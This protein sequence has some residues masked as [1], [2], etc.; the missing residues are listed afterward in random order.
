MAKSKIN[1]KWLSLLKGPLKMF[2]QK[3]CCL[4]LFI[5]FLFYHFHF[6]TL[7]ERNKKIRDGIIRSPN[8]HN[9]KKSKLSNALFIIF[10]R[11][12]NSHARTCFETI[13]K[14][15][16]QTIAPCPIIRSW[17]CR[18]GMC[19]QN[20]S[21]AVH[22]CITA[23]RSHAAAV[24]CLRRNAGTLYMALQVQ[25]ISSNFWYIHNGRKLL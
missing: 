25:F 20:S 12:L 5:H 22:C 2:N 16:R 18:R 8:L 24:P 19:G 15:S 9:Q 6:L 23:G 21:A 14:R 17:P 11:F 10:V 4:S 3:G 13:C 1:W 7:V